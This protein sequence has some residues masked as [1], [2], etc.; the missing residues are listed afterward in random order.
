[1][2][3]YKIKDYL[4]IK[5]RFIF[6]SFSFMLM[7][8]QLRALEVA[9]SILERNESSRISFVLTINKNKNSLLSKIK[10]I[11][12]KFTT[13]DFGNVVAEDDFLQLLNSAKL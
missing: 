10:P 2:D 1:M 11:I 5:F 12:K 13:V 4:K 3:F 6:F 9:K 8:E 7:K